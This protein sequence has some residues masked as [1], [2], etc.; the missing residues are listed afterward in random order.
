MDG[1]EVKRRGDSN[2]ELKILL[3]LDQ[4]PEKHKLSPPLSQLLDIHTDTLPNVI[5]ALWQYIKSHRLQDADDRR[6]V[7]CDEKLVGVLL[8]N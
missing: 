5:M 2:V 7:V 6:I 3:Y 8:S 1:F 4:Q